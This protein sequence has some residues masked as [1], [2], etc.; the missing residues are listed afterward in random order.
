MKCACFVI[1]PT[2]GWREYGDLSES[3]PGELKRMRCEACRAKWWGG[4]DKVRASE[5]Y[6][7]G[8]PL[9]CPECGW[10]G[11]VKVMGDGVVVGE[12]LGAKLLPEASVAVEELDDAAEELKFSRAWVD[13]FSE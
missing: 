12:S 4:T 2:D 7:D 1:D 11:T 6:P 13:D 10:M 3:Y 9:N 5:A 8:C